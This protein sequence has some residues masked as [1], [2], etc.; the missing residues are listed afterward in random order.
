VCVELVFAIVLHVVPLFTELSQRKILPV[1]PPKVK[2]P[3]G[4]PSHTVLPP[5]TDPGAVKGSTVT[6]DGIA[7]VAEQVLPSVTVTE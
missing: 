6:M 2:T 7:V 5:E 3:D 4:L 1:F